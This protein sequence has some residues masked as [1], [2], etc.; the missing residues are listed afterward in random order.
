MLPAPE[1]YALLSLPLTD[2]G[3]YTGTGSCTLAGAV[4]PLEAHFRVLR[5]NSQLRIEGYAQVEG[6]AGAKHDFRLRLR[7]GPS[8][9][10]G[11]RF[12]YADAQFKQM[13]G[14][15]TWAHDCYLLA[16]HCYAP[17]ATVGVY[18]SPEA[19][20]NHFQLRGLLSPALGEPLAFALAVAPRD[21]RASVEPGKTAMPASS[22]PA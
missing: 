13:A 15:L 8:I 9:L 12:E 3:R 18:L 5:Q 19:A 20:D 21:A 17:N 11:G 6:E 10:A 22:Q 1:K 16:G 7:F 2:S 4:L 14:T